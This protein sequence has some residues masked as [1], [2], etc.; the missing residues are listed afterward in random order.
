MLVCVCGG[1]GGG[2][3]KLVLVARNLAFNSN[4][5]PNYKYMFGP[6]KGPQPDL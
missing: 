5:N 6:H 2:C 3:L 4:A 1:R